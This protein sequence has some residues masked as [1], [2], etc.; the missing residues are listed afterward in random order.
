MKVDQVYRLSINPPIFAGNGNC[1][2]YL[3]K[4]INYGGMVLL[5]HP[6]WMISIK[7]IPKLLKT[8]FIFKSKGNKFIICCNSKFEYNFCKI[9]G[10]N[11]KLFNQNMH[12]CEH[13]FKP[14]NTQKIYDAFYAAQARG[15]KR[16]HLA[17]LVKKLYIL[18]YGCQSYT[19]DE[20]NDLSLFEPL[21]AHANWNKTFI[22][23]R[24]KIS[25]L[26]SSSY[27]GIA[28]SKK[29]GA[30]WASVQY[31]LCGIPLVTT[32]SRGGRDYFYDDDYV[33]LVKDNPKCILEG[34]NLTKK[35]VYNPYK[36]RNKVLKK[37]IKHRYE[38]LDFIMDNF[39]NKE[40]NRDELYDFIWG[41]EIGIKKHLY[42]HN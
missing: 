33:V 4:E 23:E 6:S 21:I 24:D 42:E 12:E 5:W 36:I 17:R 14:V 20:G 19:N 41:S 34:V 22:H 10:L 3:N 27:C 7:S 39:L 16:M 2:K 30:M 11:A 26:I 37:M 13:E 18:T 40:S 31:L 15:F 1:I 32:P 25:K 8:Q 38:Y 29:E 9:F 35:R 28:L